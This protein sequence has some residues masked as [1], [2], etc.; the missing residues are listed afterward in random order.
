MDRVGQ[1]FNLWESLEKE[2][3]NH[4]TLK[5]E[6]IFLVIS[7]VVFPVVG[8]GDVSL[9]EDGS[10]CLFCCD[11]QSIRISHEKRMNLLQSK[12]FPNIIFD[13]SFEFSIKVL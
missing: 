1:F 4:H 6:G 2:V 8:V 13:V 11:R 5:F 12:R 3:M 7:T 10:C 9:G